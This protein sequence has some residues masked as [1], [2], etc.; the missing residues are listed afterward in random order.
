M[1]LPR[2]HILERFNCFV[3]SGVIGSNFA[4]KHC[5][6]VVLAVGM[7]NILCFISFLIL[8]TETFGL[9]L[10]TTTNH[11]RVIN[12]YFSG[13]KKHDL[14]LTFSHFNKLREQVRLA[15]KDDE[16]SGGLYKII[17]F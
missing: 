8:T 1:L 7:C 14:C 10:F 17:L 4:F 6:A 12:K 9:I 15:R 11:A 13:L 2:A 16:K 3:F 5:S